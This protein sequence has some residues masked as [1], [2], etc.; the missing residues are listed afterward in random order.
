M[1]VKVHNRQH[2]VRKG[3]R[4]YG[5]KV[6]QFYFRQFSVIRNNGMKEEKKKKGMR[7][8]F[9]TESLEFYCKGLP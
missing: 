5:T 1:Q 7:T 6:F 2:Q 4:S 8:L 9:Q 3:R